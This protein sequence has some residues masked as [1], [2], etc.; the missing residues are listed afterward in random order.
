MEEIK[1][2]G[3][4]LVFIRN[5]SH[6][7][8]VEVIEETKEIGVTFDGIKLENFQSDYISIGE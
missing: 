6:L 8:T 5:N 1:D 7:F 4:L 2:Y 3:D